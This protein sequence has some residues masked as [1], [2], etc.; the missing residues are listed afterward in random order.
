MGSSGMKYI[1]EETDFHKEAKNYRLGSIVHS[2]N[3]AEKY[4]I[5][6]DPKGGE[7]RFVMVSLRDGMVM[8]PFGVQGIARELND[9]GYIPIHTL[10][11]V[12]S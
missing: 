12:P 3:G 6:Y 9:G 2:A 1:W 5:G 8:G 4:I 7:Y 11:R 10:E